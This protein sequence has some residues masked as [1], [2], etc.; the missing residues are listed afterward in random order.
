MKNKILR[1]FCPLI[2]HLIQS[3]PIFIGKGSEAPVG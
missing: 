1:E 2:S 3:L